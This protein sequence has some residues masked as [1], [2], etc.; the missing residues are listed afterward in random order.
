MGTQAVVKQNGGTKPS[1]FSEFFKPWNEWFDEDVVFGRIQTIPG[2]NISEQNNEYQVSLAVPGMK[3]DDFKILVDGNMLTVSCEK[4][5]NREE[6][7]KR[8]T[9][10]EY[11][12]SAFSRS[13]MIPESTN[14]EKID[15]TY[16]DGVLKLSLPL[17]EEAKKEQV[18]Q[19]PIK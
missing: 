10:K 14:T 17:K 15:A 8:F 6:K 3:K 7:D 16:H 13:F 19:I 11:S 1:I 4:E 2:V 5:E 18:K 9:R 12:Y